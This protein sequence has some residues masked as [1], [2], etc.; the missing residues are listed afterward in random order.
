LKLYFHPM[1]TTSRTVMLF[2]TEANIPIEPVVVD[3]MTGEHMKEPFLSVNPNAQVPV[4][5]DNDFVLTECSAIL[6]YLA[7]KVESPAYPRDLMKRARVN[8]RM[9]WFNT[10]HYREWGYHLIYPQIFP[11]HL[12]TPEAAQKATLEWGKTQTEIWLKRLDGNVLGSK[13]YLCGDQIT[14]A[15]Y[16]G[17]ELLG[18]GDLI[19]TSFKRFPNVDRWMASMRALPGWKKVN[20]AVEGYAASLKGKPFVTIT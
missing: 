10:N 5:A 8:E 11:S 12:R 7:D 4:L 1:S 15:D 18:V 6:K 20:E 14:I 9:D 16:F 2:C 3:M 17:A 13:R 19:G